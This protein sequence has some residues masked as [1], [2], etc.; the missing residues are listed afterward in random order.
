MADYS[1]LEAVLG[2]RFTDRALLEQALRH[3]SWCNEHATEALEDNEEMF[4]W[5]AVYLSGAG[6]FE[7]AVPLFRKVFAINPNWRRFV[8]DMVRLGHLKIDQKSLNRLLEL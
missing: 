7:E 1:E 8:P 4:F 2:Y 6:R 3:A 5:H